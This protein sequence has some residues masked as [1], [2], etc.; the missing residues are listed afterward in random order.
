[1]T[2]NRPIRPDEDP[3]KLALRRFIKFH[4]PE[5]LERHKGCTLKETAHKVMHEAFTRKLGGWPKSLDTIDHGPRWANAW[6]HAL[7]ELY[8]AGITEKCQGSLYYRPIG[9]DIALQ[10]EGVASRSREGQAVASIKG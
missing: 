5:L 8:H 2:R 3:N 9:C 10:P 6:G 1:M 4:L 7:K